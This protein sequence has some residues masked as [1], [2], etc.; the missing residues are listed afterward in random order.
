[1]WCC[2]GRYPV[3]VDGRNELVY[4]PEQVARAARLL[5]DPQALEA[6]RQRYGFEWIL[7]PTQPEAVGRAH[8]DRDPRWV[9]VH[10]S[11]AAVV[12]VYRDGQ[13]GEIARRDG[14]RRLRA[15]DLRR[16]ILEGVRSADVRV[17]RE[18]VAEVRRMMADDP[19]SYYAEVA[20]AVAALGREGG[21]RASG[22]GDGSAPGVRE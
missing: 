11:Q 17:R 19:T 15:F 3:Y 22:S 20:M 10:Q 18:T 1:M 8:V 13:N 16:S 2:H 12:Y 6:E 14:Y 7:A 4:S 21:G 9:L 5:D